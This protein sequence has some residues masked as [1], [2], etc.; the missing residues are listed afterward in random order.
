MRYSFILCAL[1]AALSLLPLLV[2]AAPFTNGSFE[3]ITGHSAIPSGSGVAIYPTNTWLTGWTVGGTGDGDVEVYNGTAD[4]KSP[5]DGS[6]FVAFDQ[7]DTPV[8]GTLSQTFDTTVGTSYTVSFA[9]GQ[10]NSS[11][12]MSLTA[13]VA[14]LNGSVI[15]SNYCV[16][17]AGAWSTFQLSFTAVSTNSTLMFKDTSLNTVAVDVFLDGVILTAT[18]SGL[19]H[20]FTNGN[21][22]IINNHAAIPT[23]S[24]SYITPGQTW[25][26]GWTVGGPS[27]VQVAVCNGTQTSLTPPDEVGW[28]IFND[29]DSPVGATLSQAF[30]TTVGISYTVGFYVGQRNSGTMSVTATVAALN[31]SLLASNYCAGTDG[32]WTLFQMTFTAV[33]TNSTLMF[34]DT[35]LDTM[36]VDVALDDVTVTANGQGGSVQFTAS[37][38]NGTVPL[39]VSF[40][41]PSADSLGNSITSWN[42]AFGD[43]ATSTAQNPSHTYTVSSNYSP[44]LNVTNSYGYPIS[45]TGPAI[46]VYLTNSGS[47][48]FTVL[49]TFSGTDG[50]DPEGALVTSGNMLYGTTVGYYYYLDEYYYDYGTVFSLSTSGANFTNLFS[51]T[52]NQYGGYYLYAGVTVSGNTLFGTSLE[53]G[54]DGEGSVFALNTDGSSYRTLH[55]FTYN[56]DGA[57]PYD[58]LILAGNTL[59]GTTYEGGVH[60]YGTVFALGTNGGATTIL[61]SFSYSVDGAY[62]YAGLVLAGDTLYGTTYEGGSGSSYG[63]VFSVT[64]NGANF[65]VLHRFSYSVDGAYPYSTLVVSG[66]TLYG[67]AEEGGINGEGVIFSLNTNG[68]GFTNLH[69]FSYSSDGEYPVGGVIL[70]GNTLYGAAEYGGTHGYGTI[71]ALNTDGTGF[72]NLHS[73]SFGTDG[74]YPIGGLVFSGNTLYGTAEEGGTNSYG[75]VFSLTVGN[76]VVGPPPGNLQFGANPTT[77]IAPLAVNFASPNV[78]SQTNAILSWSWAFGDGSSDI[79]QNPS[80]IY[81]NAGTYTPS[82]QC[83]NALGAIISASGPTIVVSPPAPTL[84]FTASPTAGVAPLTVTF[85]SPSA[86]NEGNGIATWSWTYGDGST[87]NAQTSSHIYPGSGTFFPTLI[88]T[89]TN[90]TQIIASG[91]VI[92]VYPPIIAFTA[93]PAAGS[94]P[95]TVNFISASADLAGNDLGSWKWNFGD[96]YTSTAQS[97]SHTYTNAGS[98]SPTLIATNSAGSMVTGFGP[99][100]IT[101]T[102]IIASL[103]LVQNGGFETGDLTGWTFSGTSVNSINM[104]VDNGSESLISPRSGQYLAALGSQN[105]LSY[106]SQ[107]LATTPGAS[108]LLSLWLNSPDGDTP[109]Q[110]LVSWNG[111]NLFNQINMPAINGWT[112]LQYSVSATRTSTVLQIGS[113]D[114]QS[115]FGLDDVSV[116]PTQPGIGSLKISGSSLVLNGLNGLSGGTYYVLT[117]TNLLQPLSKWTP[118]ATNVL[119]SNGNFTV[120]INKPVTLGESQRYYIIKYQ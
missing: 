55:S 39:N 21:F 72:T 17:T 27:N 84:A 8:G 62:P 36:D 83:S 80:H 57:L 20:P 109:N 98:F 47:N 38:T 81:T 65:T 120:T 23:N 113:Q 10:N 60:G 94:V 11:G 78:D 61:H 22:N 88:A 51:N 92:S 66:G 71:F 69:S 30:D 64:T 25:L 49:H 102:N 35:S 73:F 59:Y 46:A 4:S 103:G 44:T 26:T 77:G 6:Q 19:T 54:V 50:S 29:G 12:T 37:P 79:T 32:V 2:G 48:V 24:G 56:P 52:Q 5:Y 15:G 100:S 108:Y 68:S 13:T 105:S 86:D 40:A 104:F 111:T 3:V 99:A 63:T 107:T 76:V 14:A 18:G 91:P 112:N 87:T 9:V 90:G 95:L 82:L 16:A 7:G 93:T 58:S 75:T 43:G 114:D 70:A 45:A 97:P 119:S 53:G 67:T 118:V 106:L 34:K 42:W 101:A 33:S 28:V 96:G 110:F 31:G 85:S 117:G 116:W 74:G 1:T 115:Y 41:S 89:N